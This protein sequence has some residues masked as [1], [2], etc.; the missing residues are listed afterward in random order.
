[1]TTNDFES[2]RKAKELDKALDTQV[3]V[4]HDMMDELRE[5]VF[6]HDGKMT[7][8]LV[9]GVLEA[10]KNEILFNSAQHYTLGE[11]P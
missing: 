3:D 7:P 2:R 11:E 8:L 5:V 6:R 10:L 4:A 1:M 9:I